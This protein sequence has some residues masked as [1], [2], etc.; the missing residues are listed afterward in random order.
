MM[1]VAENRGGSEVA[2]LPAETRGKAGKDLDFTAV[3]EAWFD[4]VSRWARALG[5]PEADLDDLCQEVFIVVRR[6]LAEFDGRNLAGWLYAITARTVSDHRR[7]AWFRRL[8]LRPRD[9]EL[10]DFAG[11]GDDP[12][13]ALSRKQEQ[14]LVHRLVAKMSE[15]RR[16]AFVL[17]EIEGYGGEEI[18]RLLDVPVATVWTRLHHARKEFVELVRAQAEDGRHG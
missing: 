3:Y 1:A 6:R 17:F 12:D 11:A 16:T 14:Q 2:R 4:D 13:A 15:K 9:V 8:F 5:G 7:R 10:D 18:A